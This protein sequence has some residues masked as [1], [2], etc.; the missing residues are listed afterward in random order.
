[1]YKINK[2]VM[3]L[4]LFGGFEPE[5]IADIMGL[6]RDQVYVIIHEAREKLKREL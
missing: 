2:Q 5:E 3:Y 1:M 6:T 4:K